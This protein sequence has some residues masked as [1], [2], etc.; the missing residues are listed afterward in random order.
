VYF[1]QVQVQIYVSGATICDLFV[2]SPA[3]SVTVE[4]HRDEQFLQEI[5]PK[6]EHFCFWNFF[7]VL[8]KQRKRSSINF[9][10]I[11]TVVNWQILFYISTYNVKLKIYTYIFTP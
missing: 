8:W 6:M 9:Q 10:Q 7:P 1:G 2:Y 11:C 5:I 3:G 4:A